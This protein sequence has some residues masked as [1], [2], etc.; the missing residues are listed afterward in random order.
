MRFNKESA[1][2]V[3]PVSDVVADEGSIVHFVH[4]RYIFQRRVLEACYYH[5][6][7]SIGLTA[8]GIISIHVCLRPQVRKITGKVRASNS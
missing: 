1:R 5:G 7:R 2:G 4:V 6:Q 3:L 8:P